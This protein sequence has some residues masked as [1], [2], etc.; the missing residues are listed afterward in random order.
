MRKILRTSKAPIFDVPLTQGTTFENRV[1]PSGMVGA[2]PDTVEVVE[3]FEAE[4]RQVMQNLMNVARVGGMRPQDFVK[5]TAFLKDLNYFGIFNR[6][7]AEYFGTDFPA[8]AVFEIPSLA[9]PYELEVEGFGFKSDTWKSVKKEIIYTEKAPRFPVPLVQGVKVG[10][11]IYPSGQVPALPEDSWPVEGFEDQ[12]RQAI[13]NLIAVVEAGGGTKESIIKC[14]VFMKD[15]SRFDRFNEVYKEF[16]QKENNPPAR[17]C[18]GVTG[19]AGPY[20]MEIEGVAYIGNDIERLKTQDAPIFDMPFCQGVR[21]E[22]MVYVSGQVGYNP[23]TGDVPKTFEGQTRLMM[24]NLLAVAREAGAGP[25]DFVKTTCFLTD[26]RNFEFFNRI[27][28][29]YFHRDF[30]ARSAFQVAGLA[31]DYVVEI[32]GIACVKR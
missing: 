27:Y 25:D 7:Y 2:R 18:F 10:N 3:G 24:E 12:I 19:L 11:F 16:F 9:G 31:Y 22:E 14:V 4:V 15:M 1:F 13:K 6:I 28:Q 32:D 5:C 21:A 20:E 30:P 23:K 26:I 17:S 29:E 8:R